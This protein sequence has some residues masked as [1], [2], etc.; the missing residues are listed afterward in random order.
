MILMSHLGRPKAGAFEE[1]FSLAPVA[2]R[3]AELLDMNVELKANWRHD[4][5]VSRGSVSLIENVRF[6]YG[7]TENDSQLSQEFAN[8]CDVF[9]MDAFGTA[10]RS[11][12]STV[13]VTNFVDDVCAGHLMAAEVDALAKIMQEPQRPLMAVIGGAKV[14][15]KIDV[16]HRLSGLADSIIVGGGMANTFM[17]ANGFAVGNSLVE[18]DL[19]DITKEIQ[20]K[21]HVAPIV[22]VMTAHEVNDAVSASLRLV[23]EVESDEMILDIGP[24][25]ARQFS[26][27]LEK[28]K[29]I[30]WN[31]PMGV[32][33]YSQFGEGTRVVATAIAGSQ[34]FSVAGG[35]DTLAAIERYDV[36]DGIGYIS[37]GGGAFLEFIAGRKLPGIV[38]LEN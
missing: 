37:T 14:S 10:H 4:F 21:V 24:E 31:G 19:V 30:I 9:V 36:R 28:A 26:A 7:E 17:L 18:P 22:D 27:A 29:T 20:S 8:L 11:H 16:L 12:A 3:L 13:G 15:T 25:T 2:S 35:G 5:D 34:A 32:F 1:R 38:A 6:E 33:E 23:D